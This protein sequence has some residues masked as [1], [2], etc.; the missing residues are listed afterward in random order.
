MIRMKFALTAIYSLSLL[1]QYSVAHFD[2]TPRVEGGR[3]VAGGFDDEQGES[4]GTLRV[5]GYDFGETPEDPYN[6][7]DPGFNTLGASAFSGGSALRLRALTAGGAYLRYWDGTGSPAF[8]PAAAGTTV[9]LSASPSRFVTFS[10]ASAV[11]APVS[12]SD[13]QIGTFAANGALHAHLGT[14]IAAATATVPTGAYLI[15]FDLANPGTSVTASAPLYVVYNNG[16]SESQHDAAI[17]AAEA[18]YVPEP[19][20]AGL[21]AGVVALLRRRRRG[22]A[23]ESPAG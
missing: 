1:S 15:A 16:L 8:T 13:L 19:A 4:V 21:L 12:A 14:S 11:V 3:I 22:L 6:I 9:T 7:N 18:A 10:A 23:T 5:S 20:M 2:F 17:D